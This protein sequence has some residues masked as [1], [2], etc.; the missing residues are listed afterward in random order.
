MAGEYVVAAIEVG[1][2]ACHFEDA[3]VGSGAHI[4]ASHGI[5]QFGKSG[6]VGRGELAYHG[7]RHLGIAMHIGVC[8]EAHILNGARS[9]HAFAYGFARL[10]VGGRRHMIEIHRLHIDV[11]VHSRR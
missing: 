6:L 5:F 2:G 3:V 7:G 9:H 11:E 10:A 1:D 4:E 8:G